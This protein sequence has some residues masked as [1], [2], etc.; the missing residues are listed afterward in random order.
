MGL[1]P[2]S[3]PARQCTAE[4]KFQGMIRGTGL[5]VMPSAEMATG[6]ERWAEGHIHGWETVG[7]FQPVLDDPLTFC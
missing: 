2:E 6:W 5:G 1:L 3:V 7:S 4:W